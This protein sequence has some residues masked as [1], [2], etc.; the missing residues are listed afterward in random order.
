MKCSEFC[1]T[2]TMLP[3]TEYQL[4]LIQRDF[5]KEN[6]TPSILSY[7]HG[8]FQLQ[9]ARGS[10]KKCTYIILGFLPTQIKIY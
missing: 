9:W 8:A 2:D 5:G 4:V 1:F 6:R 10:I 3:A 7:Y